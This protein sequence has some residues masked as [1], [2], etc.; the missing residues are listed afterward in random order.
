MTSPTILIWGAG[1]IGRGFIADL[2]QRA[3]Y[4][5]VLVDHN[6]ELVRH[7]NAAG[8]YTLAVSGSGGKYLE[9]AVD[10]FTALHTSQ[11]G[12]LALAV[13]E[14]DLLAAAVF[15]SAFEA[16]A[17]GLAPGLLRRFAERPGVPLDI[18]LCGNQ[19]H[20][21]PLFRSQLEAALPPESRPQLDESVGTVE[22]L[23]IR[24][25]PAPPA[26]RAAADPLLVWSNDY[27]ELP[28]ERAAFKG[29]IPAVPGLRLV[30]DMRA[31]EMRKMYTYNTAQA[32][33]G[34]HGAMRGYTKLVDCLHD[35]RLRAE[36][37]GALDESSRALQAA[38]GFSATEMA[39][40]TAGVLD[41][42]DNP[43]LGDA[44]ERICADPARKLARA[45]RLTGPALLALRHGIQPHFLARAAAAALRYRPD[46]EA[47]AGGAGD[48]RT[49]IRS[50]CGLDERDRALE[51]ALVQAYQRLPREVEWAEKARRAYDLGF[52]YEQVYHGCGQSVLA[53][54]LETLDR[55]DP[56][57]FNAATG[58]CGGLGLDGDATCS[59]LTGAVMAFG[60]LYPRTRETFDGARAN[61]YKVF[62]LA[63]RLTTRYRQTFGAVR[64]HDLHTCLMG[65]PFDLRDTS[66]RAAFE[67][68]GA[69]AVHCVNLVG[70]AAQWA[71]ELI[72]D[73]EAGDTVDSEG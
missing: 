10:N 19:M 24:M 54:V 23:V 38:Y 64:C 66:E 22:T 51:D 42:I 34:Y 16:V 67:E 17:Q 53:A 65:R 55:F 63:Q 47:A 5:L 25:V 6:A 68:A 44:V 73:V 50:F 71:V 35:D 70:L 8:Q 36:A 3:G 2:F 7:L 40:W 48:L 61:K 1:K 29:R 37:E 57:A 21:G 11:A 46:L 69:H 4:R 45:D 20:A 15:P 39:R 12:D 18:L 27:S 58:L 72:A 30:D 41:Q 56:G 32:V 33:L 28:V 13:A 26:E 9:R 49:T 14:A 31:E 59:A 60:V 52:H 62:G 43:R